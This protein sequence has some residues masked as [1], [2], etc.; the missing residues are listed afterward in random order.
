VLVNLAAWKYEGAGG[1]IDLVMAFNHENFDAVRAVSKQQNRRG[2]EWRR[3]F[4][5]FRHR[6]SQVCFKR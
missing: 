1:E 2:S 6:S 3:G 5:E 4:F